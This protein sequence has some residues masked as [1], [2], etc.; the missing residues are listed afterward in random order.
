MCSVAVRVMGLDGECGAAS[1]DWCAC[2]NA[3]MDADIIKVA[4]AE[5][6]K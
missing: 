1:V 3:C 2:C 6:C 4:L 5:M